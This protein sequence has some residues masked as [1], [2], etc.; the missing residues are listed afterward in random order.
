MEKEMKIA[1]IGAI[2][3][4]LAAMLGGIFQGTDFFNR[5]P[6][7]SPPVLISF[8]PDKISPQSVEIKNQLDC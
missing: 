1:L 7:D 6:T 3:V 8:E 4:I 2:A 5:T